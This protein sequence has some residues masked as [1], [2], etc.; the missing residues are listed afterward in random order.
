LRQF[1]FFKP[2]S[3]STHLVSRLEAPGSGKHAE[4]LQWGY[5]NTNLYGSAGSQVASAGRDKRFVPK[6]PVSL[7]RNTVAFSG[8][9]HC[10]EAASIS[11]QRKRILAYNLLASL[12]EDKHGRFIEF[13]D[14]LD[15]RLLCGRKFFIP[16]AANTLS[17]SSNHDYGENQRYLS[18]SSPDNYV[19]E[20]IYDSTKRSAEI[21]HQGITD[22]KEERAKQDFILEKNLDHLFEEGTLKGQDNRVIHQA[23]VRFC[24]SCRMMLKR[25]IYYHHGRLIRKY[26]RCDIFTPKRFPCGDPE[27]RERLGTIER[28]CEHMYQIHRAPTMIK[29]RVFNNEAE[30]QEF[31]VDLE[32]TGNYRMSRGNK[33]VKGAIVQYYRCN[34]MYST[35]RNKTTRLIDDIAADDCYDNESYANPMDPFEKETSTKPFLRTEEACTAFFRKSYLNDGGIEVRYCDYHLHSDDRVRLPRAVRSRIFEMSAK[36]LPAPVIVMVLRNAIYKETDFEEKAGDHRTFEENQ[37]FRETKSYEEAIANDV[38]IDE[39]GHGEEGELTMLE[40]ATLEEYERDRG[41]ILTQFQNM[42]REENRKRLL[43]ERVRAEVYTIGRI[44]RNVRFVN[45]NYDLLLRS[46]E[47]LRA[48]LD[49]WNED[50]DE[51]MMC[52]NNDELVPP[53]DCVEANLGT[54]SKCS[55]TTVDIDAKR[56]DAVSKEDSLDIAPTVPVGPSRK[57]RVGKR[58]VHCPG[59][60]IEESQETPEEEHTDSTLPGL[61]PIAVTRLGRVVKRKKILDL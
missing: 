13:V 15:R 47:I 14:L 60:A 57:K 19:G 24:P 27:C 32:S 7:A 49:L 9:R 55:A 1:R 11:N 39:D 16:S 61:K 37:E 3:D 25:A 31:L 53:S 21:P 20:K 10:S 30:F 4:Q 59:P 26:G 52:R 34:R 23:E 29:H 22:P 17:P 45:F 35:P 44:M 48:L 50:M 6:Y 41:S 12:P 42:R 58:A 43:R 38:C 40:L 5:T 28:L 18:L 51:G 56:Q 8:Q 2:S 54:S 36:K 33:T 46:H